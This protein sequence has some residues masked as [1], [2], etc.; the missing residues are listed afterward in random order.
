MAIKLGDAIVYLKG[1]R[2]QLTKDLQAGEQQTKGWTGAVGTM[3]GQLMAGAISGGATLALGAIQNLGTEL[4][5]IVGDA[6]GLQAVTNTFDALTASIGTDAVTAVG[7]LREAT[8]GMV[9]DADLMQAGNKFFAMGLADT[10]EGAAE[11]AEVATQLGMAM[12]EDATSSMENFALMMANQ[13]IPRLDSFGISSG[14]V[15]ER[16]EELM[17]ETEGLTREQAFNQAVMEQAQ[18]TMAKVG[19]QGGGAAGSMARIKTTIANLR[20]EIG[21]Y[22]LPI[23]EK[24]LGWAGDKLPV[25][26]NFL[27]GIWDKLQARFAYMRQVWDQYLRPP[28][29]LLQAA[30][31]RLMDALGIN[32]EGF[33]KFGEIVKQVFTTLMELNIELWLNIVIAAINGLVLAI[34]AVVKVID[35]FKQGWEA[36]KSLQLPDWLQR[37]SPSPIEQ[38]LANTAD[39]MAD[40]SLQAIPQFQAAFAG[41]GN[42]DNR[43]NMTNYG[44]VQIYQQPGGGNPLEQ[45]WELG[46]V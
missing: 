14:K 21:Q 34:E 44:G 10:A 8:R 16:I 46:A 37:K 15:R 18:I 5:G 40:L 20:M 23:A 32:G 12:G 11:L 2:T 33:G 6:V 13:S 43:R 41:M 35:F 45:L 3:A 27:R 42:Q 29:E 30:F 25:A 4:I 36:I 22:F 24:V 28:L 38:A 17:A 1:D 9:S 26:I 39:L 31:A 19:E 7:Q